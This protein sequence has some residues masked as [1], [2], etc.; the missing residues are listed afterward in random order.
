M[1][2]AEHN[3]KRER[4]RGKKK[5]RIAFEKGYT[6]MKLSFMRFSEPYKEL[7]NCLT[8]A[9]FSFGGLLAI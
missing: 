9:N 2:S 6:A 4:K 5:G 7:L 8:N 3:K 1:Y